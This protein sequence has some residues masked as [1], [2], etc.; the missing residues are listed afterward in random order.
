[1]PSSVIAQDNSQ[2]SSDAEVFDML[3]PGCEEHTYNNPLMDYV[4]VLS[5][6]DRWKDGKTLKM[7]DSQTAEDFRPLDLGFSSANDSRMA[8]V[9]DQPVS[10]AL[11]MQFPMSD[12][13]WSSDMAPL[14]EMQNGGMLDL[15]FPTMSDDDQSSNM[16]PSPDMQNGE[17]L[18]LGFPTMSDDD[19]SSHMAPSPEGRLEMGFPVES[20]DDA[21]DLGFL[22]GSG[23]DG[24]SLDLGFN[25]NPIPHPANN[26][27]NPLAVSHLAGNT[28][29]DIQLE[30]RPLEM[31]F[32]TDPV[33][34]IL[35]QSF[36][37]S[38]PD[39]IEF[40]IQ[41]AVGDLRIA[42]NW[43]EMDR[44][45]GTMSPGEAFARQQVLE[46][47]HE[48]LLACQLISIPQLST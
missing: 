35:D 23:D 38:Q 25:V 17:A 20:G 3:D 16:A 32:D 9:C 24:Q 45:G 39:P 4:D 29:N 7:L 30:D 28:V 26:S 12:D 1:M 48:L 6:H 44:A 21:F 31:G 18:D 36:T 46:S 41:R 8:N 40:V 47:T 5:A 15:G 10:D 19:Q 43:L 42:M 37:V 13:D 33:N 11:D 14:P 22:P 27:P 34:D 2:L